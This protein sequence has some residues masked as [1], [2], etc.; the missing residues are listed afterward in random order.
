MK[1]TYKTVKNLEAQID[2]QDLR[3]E[4]VNALDALTGNTG[5]TFNIATAPLDVRAQAAREVLGV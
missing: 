5:K 2:A 4:Y 1:V 3:N